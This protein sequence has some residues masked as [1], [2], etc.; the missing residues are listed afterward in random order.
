ML[1]K[2]RVVFAPFEYEEPYQFWLKQQQA[3]WLHTE[4][5]MASDL[6]DWKENLSESERNVIGNV[7]KGFT[8]TE[9]LVG[10]YWSSRVSQW[11]PKPEIAL[12]ASAFSGMEGIHAKAYAYLNESLGLNDFAAFLAEPTAKAKIDNLVNLKVKTKSDIAISLAVFSGFTEGVNLFSSF[13]ILLHFSRMNTMKGLGQIISFS[14]KDESLHSEAGCWLFRKFIEENP[15][16][17]TNEVR[18]EIIEAARST[19]ALEDDFI[20]KVFEMGPIRDLDPQDL[21][22]YIRYR[23]NTKLGDL[24]LKPN[25][26]NLDKDR[27]AKMEWFDYLTAGQEHQDFFAGRVTGYSKGVVNWDSIWEN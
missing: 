18:D 4:I 12:M 11:F 27:L 9:V 16:L 26:R 20:D 6:Q 3:H 15:S 13:A 19:V 23:T 10:E 22:Q 14:V 8:Q 17:L 5:Q 1:T 2:P 25:W 24:G 21:K 7:L